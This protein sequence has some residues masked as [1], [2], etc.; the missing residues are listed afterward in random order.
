MDLLQKKI[1][2]KSQLVDELCVL[3][4]IERPAVYRRMRFEVPFTANEVALMAA[5]WNI[6]L[7]DMIGIYSGKIAFQ[8]MPVNYL[9]PTSQD[10]ENLND[11]VKAL[12]NLKISPNSEYMVVCNNLSRSLAS[13]FDS[14]YKFNIFKWNYEFSND[15]NKV[16][17]AKMV[18][19]KEVHT[20]IKQF[21][22]NMKEA[23]TTNMVFDAMLFEN[24]VREVLFFH[25]IMMLTDKDKAM[26]KNDLLNLMNYL[27]EVANNGCFPETN[28]K[29]YLYISTLNVNTN[30]SYV[31]TDEYKICRIHAFDKFDI[32]SHNAEMVDTFKTWML[33]KKRTSIL[34]SE[35][36]EK[37][38]VA[39]FVKL[40]QL[41]DS[42]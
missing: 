41:I 33:M 21:Y 24:F 6:S 32:V 23:A 18:I 4:N 29:V 36:D 39:F 25:S 30:Y 42:L 22:S 15:T 8:M 9:Q 26:I 16:P 5:T 11:R 40:R 7:D 10:L 37:N 28:K 1:P 20:I 34:I 3:L 2:K 13:G 12:E 17:F 14:L 27:Q 35:V 38:R 31:I 19:P